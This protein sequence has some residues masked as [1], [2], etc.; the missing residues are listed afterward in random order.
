MAG[1]RVNVNSK[2]ELGRTLEEIVRRLERTEIPLDG[3]E[4]RYTLK[5]VINEAN[6][7]G[8]LVWTEVT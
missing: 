8:V 7:T 3:E 6:P 2:A 5:L 1:I 4:T